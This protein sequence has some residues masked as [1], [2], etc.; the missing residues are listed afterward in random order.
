MTEQQ[1]KFA[2][3]VPEMVKLFESK[4]FK[5]RVVTPGTVGPDAITLRLFDLGFEVWIGCATPK[6]DG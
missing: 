4:G 6:S 2:D 5:V 1:Q 3:A